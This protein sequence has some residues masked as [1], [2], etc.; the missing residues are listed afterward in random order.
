MHA[1]S[2]LT[3]TAKCACILASEGARQLALPVLGGGVGVVCLHRAAGLD[4]HFEIN[5]NGSLIVLR[6][7]KRARGIPL[8]IH[9]SIRRMLPTRRVRLISFVGLSDFG[10]A[11]ASRGQETGIME[12]LAHG[13]IASDNKVLIIKV[14]SISRVYGMH[15]IHP[16]LDSGTNQG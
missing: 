15:R 12:S 2:R 3:Q 1:T 8:R 6:I 9:I 14:L 7:Q 11:A 5:D 16:I 4:L 13:E 10:I